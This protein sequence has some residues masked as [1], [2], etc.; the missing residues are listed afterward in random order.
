MIKEQQN[1]RMLTTK[2]K[3]LSDP[4]KVTNNRL[5]SD[6]NQTQSNY[7]ANEPLTNYNWFNSK[8]A[9]HYLGIS[10]PTLRKMRKEK[11]FQV[12]QYGRRFLYSKSE[13][14]LAITKL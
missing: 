10:Q 13:L 9:S 12:H 14:D 11:L 5:A 6:K 7:K 8:Q 1:K 4:S 2:Q 3:R